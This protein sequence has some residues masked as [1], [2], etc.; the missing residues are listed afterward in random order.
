[1]TPTSQIVG[2]QAVLNVLM[3]DRY[4]TITG[5]TAGVLRGEYGAT[6]APVDPSLRARVLGPGEEAI[7][8]RPA[9]RLSPELA[10]LTM[11]LEV[12]ARE[13]TIRLAQDPVDEV[14]TY[15]MFPQVGLKFLTNRD[16][17]QAF[18]P[19][20][21][22]ESAAPAVLEPA[23]A[24]PPTDLGPETYRVEVDG[25]SYRVRVCAEGEIDAVTP[26]SAFPVAP[27]PASMAAMGR[28]VP[29]PLAGTVVQVRVKLG[30]R[31]QRG[32]LILILEAMKMETEL[33][34]PE[35]GLVESIA[36]KSGDSVQVG[37]TLLTLG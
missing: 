20:P 4:K 6:P 22:K 17:P 26:V 37:Q 15:A 3:G 23:P 32:D 12:L 28:S 21:W 29:A 27:R 33:R 36:V 5:E 1:M 19:P 30:D 18:E 24:A 34:S 7:T 14:L 35:G 9:D 31:V 8:C 16:D 11:E 25:H 2:S 10:R 13:R